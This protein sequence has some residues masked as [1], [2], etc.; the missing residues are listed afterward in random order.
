M[1][2]ITGSI[3]RRDGLSGNRPR[4]ARCRGPR[5]LC[6]QGTS[7]R[8]YRHNAPENYWKRWWMET[9]GPLRVRPQ[10]A[11]GTQDRARRYERYLYGADDGLLAIADDAGHPLVIYLRLPIGV[12][13]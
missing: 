10:G 4:G 1:A 8:V 9:C 12:V 2:S 5:A 7:E 6:R 13:A 11:P 3:S